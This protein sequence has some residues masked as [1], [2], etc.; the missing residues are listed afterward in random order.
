[1]QTRLDRIAEYFE[2]RITL[3]FLPD[4]GN[5]LETFEQLSRDSAK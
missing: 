4:A 2:F 3:Q 5:M 1:M